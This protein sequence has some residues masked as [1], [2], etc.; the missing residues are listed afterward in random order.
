MV[1]YVTP[2]Q[3]EVDEGKYVV[4]AAYDEF[5]E[6]KTVIVKAGETKTVE[7]RWYREK[8]RVP[9]LPI[10]VLGGLAVLALGREK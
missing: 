1:E 9:W 7:F 6:S 4:S 10:I 2:F 8:K 3:V 5:S